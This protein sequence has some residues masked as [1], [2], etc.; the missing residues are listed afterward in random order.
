[1]IVKSSEE[2]WAKASTGKK[3]FWQAHVVEESGEWFTK[4]SYWQETADGLSVVQWSVPKKV[5]KK[6]VGKSN[7]I[8][9][10]DQAYLEMDQ[11]ILKQTNKGYR[12][13]EGDIIFLP[14]LAKKYEGKVEYP[15][16]VQPKVD[17]IRAIQ[18]NGGMISRQGKSIIQ[19]CIQHL[20][21]DTEYILDGELVLPFGYSFQ[22]TIEAIKKYRDNSLKLLYRVYDVVID[23][24]FAE[25]YEILKS[26]KL[27]TQVILHETIICKN[28]DELKKVHAD[29]VEAGWEGTIIRI[30]DKGY[31]SN[32]RSSQLLKL[33]DF[34][35]EE[36]EVVDVITGEAKFEG[37]GILVCKTKEGKEFKV[38]PKGTEETRRALLDNRDNTIGKF[39]TVRFIN[40]TDDGL[41][42]HGVGI[43]ERSYE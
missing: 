1:M 20:I 43:A 5:T 24:P 21:I 32:K 13:G 4:T 38:V 8:S 25:R 2:Y 41:P 37:L 31:E 10:E 26:L 14:M 28:E 42:R 7:E 27:N 16:Y 17:G 3:K 23:K 11:L 22:E 33:K 12:L 29:N 34:Q 9:E 40:Y 19:E 30:S 39:W 6:N 15:I 35:D 36:F 18:S